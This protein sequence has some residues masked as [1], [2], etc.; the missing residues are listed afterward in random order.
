MAGD[1]GRGA[2]QR[3][4]HVSEEE[5]R[6]VAAAGLH[7]VREGQLFVT[8]RGHAD[9][10]KTPHRPTLVTCLTC[11]LEP[12]VGLMSIV[13]QKLSGQ[14]AIGGVRSSNRPGFAGGPGGCFPQLGRAFGVALRARAAAP[15][16]RTAACGGAGGFRYRPRRRD[17]PAAPPRPVG[18][19]GGPGRGGRAA[20]GT[21]TP[22]RPGR[23]AAALGGTA[24]GL[25]ARDRGGPGGRHRLRG[26]AEVTP[27]VVPPR[28]RPGRCG[29]GP[30]AA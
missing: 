11:C 28:V 4:V 21:S 7:L 3:S 8:G 1:R 5:A 26:G 6:R 30:G 14:V 15:G 9:G 19:R 2:R 25:R 20:R 10:P 16:A 23:G 18:V 27:P 29:S 24:R 12:Y 17:P 22:P 13:K